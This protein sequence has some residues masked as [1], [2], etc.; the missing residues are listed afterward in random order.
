MHAKRKSDTVH[1]VAQGEVGFGT[2]NSKPLMKTK[3]MKIDKFF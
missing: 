2:V 1:F 3:R